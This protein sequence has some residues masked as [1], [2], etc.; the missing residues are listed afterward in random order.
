M[1]DES[2]QLLRHANYVGSIQFSLEDGCLHGRVLHINDLITYEGDTLPQLQAEFKQV[3][4]GYLEHCRSIGKQPDKPYTGS[5]N[6]RLGAERHRGL[7]E[8]SVQRKRSLNTLL[9]EA[10]DALLAGA[11]PG[12]EAEGGAVLARPAAI[13]KQ[14]ALMQPKAAFYLVA[15]SDRSATGPFVIV[16]NSAARIGTQ[17]LLP[18]RTV[19]KA[20]G[21]NVTLS[22]TDTQ[23]GEAYMPTTTG[24]SRHNQIKH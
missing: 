4:D 10:V 2:D 16:K 15:T 23:G 6:V 18:A 22:D 19:G 8:M 3:V 11:Q 20:A 7:I 24:V 12:Q 21:Q 17:R 5:L 14:A 9:C 1:T 13:I